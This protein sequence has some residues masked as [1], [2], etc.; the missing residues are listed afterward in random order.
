MI[1]YM[2][3]L[4]PIMGEFAHSFGGITVA[5]EMARNFSYHYLSHSHRYDSNPHTIVVRRVNNHTGR[6]YK[7]RESWHK[8]FFRETCKL[9][10]PPNFR[11]PRTGQTN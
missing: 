9:I 4:T 1:K 2:Q 3:K 6:E 11:R 10:D 5:K 7:A 8:S